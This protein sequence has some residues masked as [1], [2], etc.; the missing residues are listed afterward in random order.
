M[1][2]KNELELDEGALLSFKAKCLEEELSTLGRSISYRSRVLQTYVAFRKSSE[3]V[4]CNVDPLQQDGLCPSF[5]FL[6]A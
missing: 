3:E 5:C 4:W 6:W 1:A 2:E